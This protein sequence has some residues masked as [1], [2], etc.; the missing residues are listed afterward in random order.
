[1]VCVNRIEESRDH[2]ESFEYL[3]INQLLWLKQHQ[4]MHGSSPFLATL[5]A[6]LTTYIPGIE[7]GAKP[8]L[9]IKGYLVGNGF[10]H[11]I[12]ENAQVPFARGMALISD[13]IYEATKQTC[14]GNY[15][16]TNASCQSKIQSIYELEV[17][18]QLN[19]VRRRRFAAEDGFLQIPLQLGYDDRPCPPLNFKWGIAQM[20]A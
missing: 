18:D 8:L 20:L 11:K 1:M 16:S 13:E 15:S 17:L 9:N 2:C 19:E 10:T 12:F 6:S 4:Q 3:N 14:N 7:A 5:E